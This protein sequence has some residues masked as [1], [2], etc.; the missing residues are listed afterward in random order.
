MTHAEVLHR[1]PGDELDRLGIDIYPID[2]ARD[3]WHEATCGRDDWSTT[4]LESVVEEAAYEHAHEAHPHV[5][6]I[7]H[8]RLTR[9]RASLEEARGPL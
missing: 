5:A 4:G 9:W 2:S 8:E 3:G 1:F 7:A 6:Q